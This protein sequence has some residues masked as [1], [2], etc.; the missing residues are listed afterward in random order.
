[1]LRMFM[2]DGMTFA[3]FNIRTHHRGGAKP[4]SIRGRGESLEI[5]WNKGIPQ[6]N[7]ASPKRHGV[8]SQNDYKDMRG[9]S[10]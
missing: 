7:T 2:F 3:C 10:C 9:E 8:V 5:K 1:M 6:R 4:N